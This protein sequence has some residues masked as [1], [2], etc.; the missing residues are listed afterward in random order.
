MIDPKLLPE[1]IRKCMPKEDR[2]KTGA[3]TLV[4]VFE[5]EARGE[6]IKTHNKF[7]DWCRLNGVS[8][9]HSRTDRKSTIRS[10]H[11]DFTLLWH[12]RGC[13]VEFKAPGGRLSED[14]S[15]AIAELAKNGVPCLV[16]SD[17]SAAISFAVG[18][19]CIPYVGYPQC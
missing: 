10:G 19:L 7:M 4:E 16:T 2:Q 13:C 6:E 9:V 12:G 11:P 17:L 8:F 15:E 18:Q 5:K 14:Q 3:L 1:N